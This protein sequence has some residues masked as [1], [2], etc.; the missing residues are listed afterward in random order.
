[1]GREHCLRSSSVR[2]SPLPAAP[3]APRFRRGASIFTG[4]AS[5]AKSPVVGSVAALDSLYEHYTGAAAGS[6]LGPT[7][8]CDFSEAVGM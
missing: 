3:S 5:G 8:G 7:L 4:L 1:M 6:T 2:C